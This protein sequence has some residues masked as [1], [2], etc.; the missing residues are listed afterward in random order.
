[1]AEEVRCGGESNKCKKEDSPSPDSTAPPPSFNSS[2]NSYLSPMSE[3]YLAK[4]KARELS[5]RLSQ[6][7]SAKSEIYLA[8][9]KARELS[10][11]LSQPSSAESEIYLAK[12]KAREISA[13]LSQYANQWNRTTVGGFNSS[14]YNAEVP[15]AEGGGGVYDST[16]QSAAAPS[17]WGLPKHL[18]P[19]DDPSDSRYTDY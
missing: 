7:S 5:A 3:I 18:H 1:M 15:K 10:A 6:P 13:R 4:Q 17:P 2:L 19:L 12:Q 9:Q 8:K 16:T 14:D 11:R